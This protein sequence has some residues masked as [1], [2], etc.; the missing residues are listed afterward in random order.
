MNTSPVNVVKPMKVLMPVTYRAEVVLSTPTEA[1][2]TVAT[3]VRLWKTSASVTSRL[4]M[5]AS[6]TV[7][8]PVWDC[9]TRRLVPMP[10]LKRS[11]LMEEMPV[12]S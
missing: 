4:V 10:T 7:A 9:S 1:K 11:S 3:P 6:P 12:T 2:P 5:E 8:T